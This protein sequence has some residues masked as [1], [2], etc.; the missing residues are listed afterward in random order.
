[1]N[2]RPFL[3]ACLYC[4]VIPCA[5]RTGGG[6]I[7]HD[8]RHACYYCPSLLTNIWRHYQLQHSTEDEVQQIMT[9]RVGEQK[10][11]INK[12]R[13]LGD[14]FH[15]VQVLSQKSGQ[16]IVVR[17]PSG[18]KT[19]SYEDFLPCLGCKGFFFRK[20]M[21]RHCKTCEFRHKSLQQPETSCQKEG[22]MLIAPVWYT[23]GTVSP[24]L[25]AVL[26]SMESDNIS[27]AAKNDIIILNYGG[28]VAQ[29]CTAS[30]YTYV[31]QRMRQ[32]AR[33]LIQ[34][35]DDNHTPDAHMSSFLKPEMFDTVVAA[36]LK[37]SK[38]V[39]CTKTES[40]KLTVPSLALKLGYALRKC[41][42]VL[43]NKALREKNDALERDAESFIRIYD[44]EWNVR[45]SSIALKTMTYDKRNKPELIPITADLVK[46]KQYLES[47]I[48]E[49]SDRLCAE[50]NVDNYVNLVDCTLSRII[51]F[52]KRRG[53][54]VGRMTLAAYEKVRDAN[55][56]MPSGLDDIAKTLSRA[57]QQLCSRLR[58][59]EIAGKNNQTVP[60]LLTPDAIHGIDAIIASREGVG[61]SP[62]NL[63]IFARCSGLNNVDPF[64]A[65]RKVAECSGVA[66]PELI[67]GT[68]LRKYMA[69]VSQV[70]DMRPNELSL[71]C[72][73]MG[74]SIHV[75]E[76]FYRLPSHTLE[77]AKVS[78]LLI[79]VEGGDLTEL[80]GKTMNDLDIAD[81]PNTYLDDDDS[82]DEAIDNTD[83]SMPSSS[84]QGSAVSG[85]NKNT[86]DASLIDDVEP[87]SDGDSD[88]VV[89]EQCQN[90][91]KTRES[92][93]LKLPRSSARKCVKKPWSA[94][95]KSALFAHFL[96][97]VRARKAPGKK[98]CEEAINKFP[99]LS[100]RTWKTIKFAV[101]NIIASEKKLAL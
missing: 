17:R 39:E 27:L 79:A 2:L 68:K 40:A 26:S 31:S 8:R 21:W 7:R 58:L 15:N 49:L 99:V 48:A 12:L 14:Y 41:C 100:S 82:D 74:H 78:K 75:H 1:M 52:N 83:L 62:Q 67:R 35:R 98:E 6:C 71:L 33:L 3:C 45:V 64:V 63:F 59:V 10:P 22:L 13:M 18:K 38:Y 11:R 56:V 24:T 70:L 28:F 92:E 69:T 37:V 44:S 94:A 29:N 32:L 89:F 87:S 84:K 73:H 96:S 23:A 90:G 4:L 57:E 43:V 51:L 34:L 16:L 85:R 5:T 88:N 80:A 61:I 36:V 47:A 86:R 30:Q 77:L 60:V 81:I 19:V 54:E 66:R 9:V 76:E 72:R 25:A 42:T 50:P 97:N 95:E 55:A 65:I 20:E 101:K 53:G 93:T 91:K 46:I